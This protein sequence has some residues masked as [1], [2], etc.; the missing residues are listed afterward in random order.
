MYLVLLAVR[1]FLMLVFVVAAVSKLAAG[2]NRAHK[3]LTDFGVPQSLIAPLSV[4]LPLSELA[5]C[6]LLLVARSAWFGAVLAVAMLLIFN[7]A[8]AANLAVGKKPSCNCFGQLHSKPIGWNMFARNGGLA[9]LAAG[10]VWRLPLDGSMDVSQLFRPL[11]PREI[12]I[13]IVGLATLVAFSIVG[14]LMVHLFRQNG[15][16]L[17]RM[18]ALEARPFPN[19]QAP[20]R[21]A[22]ALTGLP[23]GSKAIP[24]DLPNTKGSRATLD[25]LLGDGKPL[26]LISTDPNCGPCNSL[27]PEVALWQEKLVGEMTIA[28]LSHG[29][30]TDNQK[31]A[32][33]FGLNNVLVEKKHEIAEKYHALGTPTAVLIRSDGSIGSPAMGG[34]DAIRQ[35]VTAKAWTE[36]GFAAFITARALPPQVAPPPKAALP[37]GSRVPAFTLPDLNG[38]A[39]QS[40]EFNGNGTVLLFWNP[41]CGFCQ[42]MIPQLK[43][44]EQNKPATAS[45]LVLVSAGSREANRAMGLE[46]TVLL[47]DRFAVGQSCG[48]SGTPAG[49]MIDAKGKIASTLV[50]GAPGV[51]GLLSGDKTTSAVAQVVEART[52]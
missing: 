44:W 35:L 49:V 38:N 1:L 42:K 29:R 41:G 9:V 7:A 23:I 30:F 37:V 20:V 48:A 14:F 22:L 17:L 26:L 43:E 36:A 6:A 45:R 8:I 40:A 32:A 46:S 4:I 25:S 34:A 16:L 24:F 27:M 19:Q 11:A 33:E 52:G 2:L 21:S 3:A 39:V 28:L 12:A 51:M 18:E 5:I 13:G 31:K 47:D 10:L 50:V 15:R